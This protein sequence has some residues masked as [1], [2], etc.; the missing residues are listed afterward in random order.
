MHASRDNR[1]AFGKLFFEKAL[2]RR[3]IQQ[4]RQQPSF[5]Q[6]GLRY[7]RRNVWSQSVDASSL[8]C[9]CP[10]MNAPNA[11]SYRDTEANNKYD[12]AKTNVMKPGKCC[13]HKP[14]A[15]IDDRQSKAKDEYGCMPIFVYAADCDP[16]LKP[17]SAA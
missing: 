8:M 14:R 16:Q 4:E 5:M 15:E 3:T 6:Q 12:P 1:Y 10:L 13:E 9:F 2:T 11:R 7:R 17:S